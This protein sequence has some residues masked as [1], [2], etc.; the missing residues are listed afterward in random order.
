MTI[1]NTST[2]RGRGRQQLVRVFQPGQPH[3]VAPGRGEGAQCILVA[4]GLQRRRQHRLASGTDGRRGLRRVQDDQHGQVAPA[5]VAVAVDAGVRLHAG[6]LC[7]G[8]VDHRVEVELLAVLLPALPH[9]LPHH[10]AAHQARDLRPQRRLAGPLGA[11]RA[12][13]GKARQPVRRASHACASG[14]SSAKNAARRAL[15]RTVA[16]RPAATKS[17]KAIPSPSASSASVRRA[18][19]CTSAGASRPRR[20]RPRHQADNAAG[21]QP[22]AEWPPAAPPGRRARPSSRR[23]GR[24]RRRRAHRPRPAAA[25]PARPQ[26]QPARTP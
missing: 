23:S 26:R 8:S 18:V 12:P 20:F 6:A 10:A 25:V 9:A 24:H 3:V 2:P 17:T 7:Y 22:S 4:P 21:P 11:D 1:P 5:R 14:S 13:V 15:S 19:P 16:F